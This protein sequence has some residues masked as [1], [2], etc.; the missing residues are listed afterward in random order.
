MVKCAGLFPKLQGY[1]RR[2]KATKGRRPKGGLFSRS[3]FPIRLAVEF[4]GFHFRER[5]KDSPTG[6]ISHQT[7]NSTT[8]GIG[9]THR[10]EDGSTH[11]VRMVD[12]LGI[13]SRL[14]SMM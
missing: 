8:D 5:E 10:L 11:E 2:P 6:L 14:E 13:P 12:S 4:K 1:Q 3:G 7:N 9:K